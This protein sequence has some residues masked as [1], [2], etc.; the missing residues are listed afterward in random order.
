MISAFHID[1][2]VLHRESFLNEE[3]IQNNPYHKGTLTRGNSLGFGVNEGHNYLDFDGA[4]TKIVLNEAIYNIKS[5][6]F[7]IYLDNTSKDIIDFDGGSHSIEVSLGI[8]TATGWSSPTIYVDGVVTTTITG[9][10]WHH[11]TVTT[12]AAFNGTAIKIG[13]ETTFVDGKFADLLIW[14]NTLT[15]SEISNL[16]N[17][18]TYIN[19]VDDT[20]SQ[21]LDA[22]LNYSNLTATWSPSTNV[23]GVT[24][25]SFST[26]AG[27][28]GY[29]ART[30]LTVGKRYRMRVS[31]TQ[32]TINNFTIGNGSNSSLY[33]S[34]SGTTFDS[35]FTFTA[36]ET[37]LRLWLLNANKTV[38]FTAFE[39]AVIKQESGSPLFDVT[40]R[41]GVIIDRTGLRTI[42]NTSVSVVR[43]GGQYIINS[44]G[45]T[46]TLALGSDFLGITD[47]TI[48]GW[49]YA[50]G[51]GETS[52]DGRIITN[53]KAIAK[54]NDTND[55]L[56]FTSDG[57]TFAVGASNALNLSAWYF[58]AITR[59][60][61]G[62]TNLYVG[63][64]DAAPILSGTA[65]QDSGA[66][67]AGSTVYLFSNNGAT[68]FN[69]LS[70]GIKAS[71][72]IMTIQQITQFWSST[73]F[74]VN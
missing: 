33:L 31:G 65:N 38:I 13:S 67:S 42:T 51:W 45:T 25:T 61:N 68:T 16:C 11:V 23:T 20:T 57:S 30:T 12:S 56:N 18:K 72:K 9:S 35:T 3:S 59:T 70:L 24:S 60:T 14:N 10:T 26:S 52:G 39:I 34:T 28:S 43:K 73:K 66:P 47:L 44:N 17:N 63:S 62:T 58:V 49:I 69:G 36:T 32:T 5:V 22:D 4:A 19:L 40:A 7:W 8:L 55:T 48:I 27:G 71:S 54:I 53:T 2:R 6:S 37:T 21:I 64:K 29:L 46:S 50:F 74:L 41:Q 15:I 1:R